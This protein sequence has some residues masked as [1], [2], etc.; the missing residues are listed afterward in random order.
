MI[1]KITIIGGKGGV[2]KTTV[3]CSL[4][5]SFAQT[6]RT[7][8]ISTDPA[9]SISDALMIDIG[10]TVTPVRGVPNLDAL[11]I[12]A[13][14][15][16]RA[17]ISNHA[18]QMKLIMQTSTY[19]DDEDID[20]M[21]RVALPGMDEVMGLKTIINLIESNSHE[22]YVIDTAPTGHALRLLAMPD[23]LDTWIKAFA[24]LRWKYR[25]ISL[26]FKGGYTPDSGDDFLLVMKKTVNHIHAL[27]TDAERC[28]FI[29]VTIPTVM[30]ISETERLIKSLQEFKINVRRI[31][32]NHVFEE[33]GGSFSA[34]RVKEQQSLIAALAEKLPSYSV[35][36][37]PEM[38]NEI[39]G[40]ERLRAIQLS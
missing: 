38:A 31:V 20:M 3:A 37:I 5:L 23:L 40:T 17:F 28:E 11:E 24:N 12:N 33:D 25:E 21:M 22:C 32:I 7:L 34:A 19:L 6:Q 10:D 18:E 13:E 16:F 29:A 39:R 27:L 15:E 9:H 2:G 35:I 1:P 36:K 30:A 4:A 8:L 26:R 14:K